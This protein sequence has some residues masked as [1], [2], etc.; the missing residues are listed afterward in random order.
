MSEPND[1]AGRPAAGP[2]PGHVAAGFPW[3]PWATLLWCLVIAL[4][5]LLAVFG[6]GLVAI[7]ID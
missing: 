6:A 5:T 3:G 4:V 1:N 7:F 2:V